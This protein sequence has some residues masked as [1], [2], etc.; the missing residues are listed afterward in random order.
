MTAVELAN[1]ALSKLGISQ[2]IE[3][4]DD[5][6]REAYTVSLHYDTVLR[7]CLRRFPWPFA[8]KYAALYQVAGPLV[9]SDP[10]E[11][12]LVQAWD[13]AQAYVAG[14]VVRRSSINY[15]CILAHTNQQPPNAT[16]WSTDEEDA[17]DYANG[18][19]L[20]AYRWPTDCV[21]ARRLVD[22]GTKRRHN[23]TPIPF[24]QGRD[25]AGLIIYTDRPEAVLEYTLLDCTDLWSDDLFL[26][27]FTWSLAAAMVPALERAQK[28]VADCLQLAE[29]AY[30]V[31]RI[32]A[33]NEQQQEK[34]GDAEWIAAR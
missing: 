26:D 3:A 7:R 1:I 4:V 33:L 28:S 9:N 6:S 17:P 19:W 2:A 11:W 14:D 13:S 20:Y 12:E 18:D 5:A 23:F 31:A 32:A 21:Y 15:Y 27:Y 8:T 16:Y 10:D 22:D 25:D 24:R 30:N 29:I 34:P